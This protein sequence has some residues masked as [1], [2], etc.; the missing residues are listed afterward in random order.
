MTIAD[1]II[2]KALGEQLFVLFILV[3]VAGINYFVPYKIAFLNFYFI[4]I[5]LGAYYLGLQKALQGGVLCALMV[6]IY[7]PTFFPSRSCPSSPCW[8]CG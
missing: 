7:A 8:T 6:V 5:L 4:P 2:T 3:S 1:S